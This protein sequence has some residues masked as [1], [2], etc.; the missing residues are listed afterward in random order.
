MSAGKRPE[1]KLTVGKGR[2]G[3]GRPKGVP[4]KSTRAL[5]EAILMAAEQAGADGAGLDGVTGYLRTLA[6]TEPRA[7]STL[8][9]KVLPLQVT[10]AGDGP[11][12][13]HIVSGVPRD[14]SD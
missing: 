11:M 12:A 8:L 3:P 10:G 14:G 7:F 5:K 2:P 4:N 1:E 9:G 13:L 6:T